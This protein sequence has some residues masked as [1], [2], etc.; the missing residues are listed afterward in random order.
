MRESKVRGKTANGEW[1]YGSLVY[2]DNIQPAIYFEVGKGSVK[3]F[4]F[5][6]VRPETVGQFTGLHDKN[7]VEIYEGDIVLRQCGV[8]YTSKMYASFADG[9]QRKQTK[10]IVWNKIYCGYDFLAPP[11][12]DE[13]LQDFELI[14]NIHDNLESEEVGE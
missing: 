7:G 1:V 14:G 9:T 6:Y 5:V 4:D 11:H 12:D 8:G 2:S 3:T 10:T 13:W